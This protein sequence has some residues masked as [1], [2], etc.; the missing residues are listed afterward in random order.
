LEKVLA[1][2]EIEQ[3]SQ[4]LKQEN[5]YL[6]HEARSYHQAKHL[7]GSSPAMQPVF[8]SVGQVAATDATV[9]ILGETGTGKE[10]IARSIHEQSRRKDKVMVKLNCATLPAQLVESELFGH[11]KGAFTG[12]VEK[13]IGKFELASGG[14]IF[15]DEVG[16]MPLELQAKLLRVL[17]EREFERIGGKSILKADVRVVAATNRDLQAEVAQGRFRAD[18]YYRLNVFPIYLPPLRERRED[19]P[20]LAVH[21]AQKYCTVMHRPFRGIRETAM[22]ELLSYEW[23]GNVRELENLV[24]QAVILSNGEPLTWGRPLKNQPVPGSV[25]HSFGHHQEPERERIFAVL[26]QTKGKIVGPDGAAHLLGMRPGKLEEYE[27]AFILKALQQAGGRVR[28]IG[29]AAEFIGINPNTLD[30]RI[31]KLGIRREFIYGEN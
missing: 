12:A 5:K 25:D 3:L 7:I 17:Q 20:L 9:L 19:I 22:Q 4:Q 10:L 15:L 21:F 13:R 1:Y 6:R 8:I 16:E 18:L 26:R 31:A 27:R 24:E 14:T 23:P 28:G 2:E 29:G 11:E 30:A